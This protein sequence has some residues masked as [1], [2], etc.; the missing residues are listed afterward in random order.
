MIKRFLILLAA[1]C[2]PLPGLLAQTPK[3]VIWFDKPASYWEEA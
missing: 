1:L 2:L 3:N